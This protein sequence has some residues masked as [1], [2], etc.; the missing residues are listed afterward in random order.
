M[1]DAI[2]N[3]GA[4]SIPDVQRKIN[5]LFGAKVEIYIVDAL[6]WPPHVSLAFLP[7]FSGKESPL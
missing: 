6:S 5:G 2:N 4:S 1:G 7:L 3:M